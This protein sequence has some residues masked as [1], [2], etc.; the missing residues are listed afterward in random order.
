M[1]VS[2]QH[3]G[4]TPAAPGRERLEARIAALAE[5][6]VRRNAEALASETERIRAEAGDHLAAQCRELV[7]LS[8]AIAAA[9]DEREARVRKLEQRLEEAIDAAERPSPAPLEIPRPRAGNGAVTN[10][11]RTRD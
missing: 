11:W 8:R 4:A 6:M 7:V 5:S 2:P 9:E 1:S 3:F 10:L